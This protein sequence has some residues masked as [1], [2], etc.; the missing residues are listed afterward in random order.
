M[1]EKLDF[2][3]IIR[4]LGYIPHDTVIETVI[5]NS[6]NVGRRKKEVEN[7]ID[8]R[9][10]HLKEVGAKETDIAAVRKEISNKISSD[11]S[12]IIAKDK[13]R[14]KAI[15]YVSIFR[16]QAMDET[17]M[18]DFVY[19]SPK[20]RRKGMG[21]KLERKGV[22]YLIKKEGTKFIVG[23]PL[24]IGGEKLSKFRIKLTDR[25]ETGE[26]DEA[27]RRWKLREKKKSKRAKRK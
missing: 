11:Y 23:R 21:K 1:T 18:V 20:Y 24:S 26:F 10:K 17:G 27:L 2:E 13:K 4:K 5:V 14:G 9:S 3:E 22:F 15:G 7:I 6:E 12:F 25:A 19:V 16:P 8:L